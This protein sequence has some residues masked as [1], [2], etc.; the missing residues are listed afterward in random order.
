MLVFDADLNERNR[1]HC[2]YLMALGNLGLGNGHTS[3]AIALFDTVLQLD[4]NHQG[5]I[6]HRNMVDLLLAQGVAG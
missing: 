1:I 5:A 3:Q 4:I 6:V 2:Y